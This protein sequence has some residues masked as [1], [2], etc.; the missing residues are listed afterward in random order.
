MDKKLHKRMRRQTCSLPPAAI[1][2]W[3]AWWSQ[4]AC[5]PDVGRGGRACSR[6]GQ[7]T[8]PVPAPARA[9]VQAQG[10]WAHLCPPPCTVTDTGPRALLR[11]GVLSDTPPAAFNR[12]AFS[13]ALR[14]DNSHGSG[15]QQ[16]NGMWKDIC[17]VYAQA[18]KTSPVMCH[19]FPL[20]KGVK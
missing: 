8:C 1:D 12:P 7:D 5:A 16:V 4:E 19:T 15:S 13:G 9:H 17:R 11:R 6:S 20:Y 14:T 18:M 10:Q 3:L 2:V